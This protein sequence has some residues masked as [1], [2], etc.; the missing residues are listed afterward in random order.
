MVTWNTLSIA[1]YE[2]QPVPNTFIRQ[3]DATSHAAIILP[4]LGYTAQM[5]L[6]FYVSEM[7]LTQNADV[8]QVNYNYIDA[9]RGLDNA[10][11]HQWLAADSDATYRALIAQRSYT[12]LTVIGK[13]L[14]T[15][16]M[17]HLF[18]T[19]TFPVHTT[20]LWLT[21]VLT[22]AAVREQIASFASPSLL[23]IG[24]AD[25]Y[26]DPGTLAKIGETPT[27]KFLIV[28]GADHGMNVGDDVIQSI[29]A[30]ETTMRAIRTFLDSKNPVTNT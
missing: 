10:T 16:A 4:G 27:R 9:F 13:S 21:P 22:N 26:Y 24:T 6:L 11:Q 19:H 2:G 5:P 23:A 15:L 30:L 17:A 14:G 18:T 28:E 7:L 29:Q 3:R 12:H 1:G 20:A 25:S 8:L